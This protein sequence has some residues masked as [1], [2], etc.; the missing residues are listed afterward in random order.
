MKEF[1]QVDVFIPD[2]I[3]SKGRMK[4]LYNAFYKMFL[5]IIEQIKKDDDTPLGVM[6]SD[7]VPDDWY[8]LTRNYAVKALQFDEASCAA[9]LALCYI[10]DAEEDKGFI[11]LVMVNILYGDTKLHYDLD[12]AAYIMMVS[13]INHLGMTVNIFKDK[14]EKES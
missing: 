9:Y 14:N 13:Y 11:P 1:E 12:C 8:G 7:Y 3:M 5:D 4:F 2:D 10:V 6:M